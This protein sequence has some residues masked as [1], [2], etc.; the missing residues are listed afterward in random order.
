MKRIWY[1]RIQNYIPA[2]HRPLSACVSG[3]AIVPIA[4]HVSCVICRPGLV[5]HGHSGIAPLGL[6]RI[7]QACTVNVQTSLLNLQD[8]FVVCQLASFLCFLK[9]SSIEG[10]LLDGAPWWKT[11]TFKNIMCD[12][13][14]SRHLNCQMIRC[15]WGWVVQLSPNIPTSKLDT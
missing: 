4:T 5:A 12:P 14:H 8:S 10:N 1:K 15:Q 11:R 7:E 6:R 3:N 9:D 13:S 2:N